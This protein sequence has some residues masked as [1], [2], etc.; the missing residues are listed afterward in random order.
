M[1][2][3]FTTVV[4]IFTRLINF[5]IALALLLQFIIWL[6]LRDHYYDVRDPSPVL[7]TA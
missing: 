5:L 4:G 7:S 6:H 1:V 3:F 2:N